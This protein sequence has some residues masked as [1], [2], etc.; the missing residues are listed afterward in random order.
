MLSSAAAACAAPVDSVAPLLEA[1]SALTRGE[2][3]P[4][5]TCDVRSD[6]AEL[7]EGEVFLP[8]S[9]LCLIRV[10]VRV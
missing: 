7:P 5:W 6:E 4:R 10:R 1:L 2:A 3:S 8:I 9:E